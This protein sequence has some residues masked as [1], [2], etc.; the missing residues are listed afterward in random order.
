MI[1]KLEN[2][3]K[4]LNN[5]TET[6]KAGQGSRGGNHVQAWQGTMQTGPGRESCKY[7]REPCAGMAGNHAGMTGNHA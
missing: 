6:I 3:Q 4:S 2:I 5:M 7:G 1:K